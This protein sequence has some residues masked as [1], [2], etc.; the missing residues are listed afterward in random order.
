[1]V[2]RILILV[3]TL[4]LTAFYLLK[5]EQS[6]V[7]TQDLRFEKISHS[8]EKL[9]PWQGPWDCVFDKHHGLLWE[10]KKDDESIHDGYWTYS[11]FDGQRGVENM[12]DCYFQ[13]S[14]CDVLDLIT[15]TNQQKL[16]GVNQWRLPS[17][18]ELLTL[19]MTNDRPNENNLAVDYFP[20]MQRGDFWTSVHSMPLIKRYREINQGAV[21]VNFLHSDSL[22]LP[23][24]NAA[25]VILV[26]DKFPASHSK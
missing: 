17:H 24:R 7:Q 21:A 1:M 15:K 18:N 8:G 5:G 6:P 10:V 22:V 14:R 23:Y 4:L 16:C 20:H 9:T 3:I 12:G 13:P 11:W 19:L 25:F 2:K 26:N